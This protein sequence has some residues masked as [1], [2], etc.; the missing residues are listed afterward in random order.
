METR[1]RRD[2]T[3]RNLP[4]REGGRGGKERKRK[5]EGGDGEVD[6]YGRL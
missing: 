6:N 1:E 5:H 3:T 4:G 2:G